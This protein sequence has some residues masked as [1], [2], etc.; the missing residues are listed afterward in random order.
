MAF[1]IGFGAGSAEY[2]VIRRDG[3][4]LVRG[5]IPIDDLAALT[6]REKRSVLCPTL[7]RLAGVNIAFGP[8]DAIDALTT[9]LRERFLRA[10]PDATPMERWLAIGERGASSD[11]IAGHLGGAR[12]GYHDSY[13]RDPDDLSR[14]I[15]LLDDVPGLREGMHRMSGVSPQWSA[16]VAVWPQLEATFRAEVGPKWR[17]PRTRWKAPKTYAA[18]RAAIDGAKTE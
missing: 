9:Q 11:A 18:M 7:A 12:I 5:S 8:A 17:D 4:T 1:D 14:C 15:G 13:P 16:L 10:N 3:C 2:A 6:R